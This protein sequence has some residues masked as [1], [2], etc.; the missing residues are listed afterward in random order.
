MR[1]VAVEVL[2]EAIAIAEQARANEPE[3]FVALA[4]YLR[5][6]VS[7]R[8]GA[9]MPL[10]SDESVTDNPAVTDA[11]ERLN[12]RVQAMIADAQRGGSLRADVSGRDIGLLLVRVCAP[13]PSPVTRQVEPAV[14]ERHLQILL[15]GLRAKTGGDRAGMGAAPH[16]GSPNGPVPRDLPGGPA[17]GFAVR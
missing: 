1:E 6:A 9:V 4:R 13:L 11:C 3:P 17:N 8:V 12:H 14:A 10:L 16:L 7:A 2:D 15:D 5:G